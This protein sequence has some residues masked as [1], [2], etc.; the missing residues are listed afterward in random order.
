MGSLSSTN[1]GNNNLALNFYC[2]KE[3]LAHAWTKKLLTNKALYVSVVQQQRKYQ[4]VQFGILV[5]DLESTE[6]VFFIHY[7]SAQL[8]PNLIFYV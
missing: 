6:G 3:I 7:L 5:Y 2:G 8:P 1:D 4:V